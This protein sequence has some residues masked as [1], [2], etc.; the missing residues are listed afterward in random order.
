MASAKNKNFW[1]L[2]LLLAM[3]AVIGGFIGNLL[4]NIFPLLKFG[5]DFG[6]STHTWDLIIIQLTF[7]LK[8]TFNMF[9]VLGIIIAIIIYRRL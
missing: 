8:I 9:T 4:G 1:W 2:L 5:Y 6:V 3:G 7:G